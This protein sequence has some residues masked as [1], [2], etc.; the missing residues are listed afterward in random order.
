MVCT[1]NFYFHEYIYKKKTKKNPLLPGG[2]KRCIRLALHSSSILKPLSTIKVEYGSMVSK[3]H[4]CIV[5][6]LSETEPTKAFETNKI[7]EFPAT[8]VYTFIVF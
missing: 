1:C 6:D 4:D 2:I 8:Q 5:R 7:K 3:K